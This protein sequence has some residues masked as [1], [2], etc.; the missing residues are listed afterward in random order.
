MTQKCK[1]AFH[2]SKDNEVLVCWRQHY[3]YW[4]LYQQGKGFG[5]LMS[6][7]VG[8]GSLVQDMALSLGRHLG[9][10]KSFC[11]AEVALSFSPAPSTCYGC[12]LPPQPLTD[13]C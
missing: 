12:C 13:G 6:S 5:L 9:L 10:R 3:G 4:C 11:Q 2:V 7:Y 1:M 8:K